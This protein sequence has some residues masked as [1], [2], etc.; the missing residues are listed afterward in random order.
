[1][2]R[3]QRYSENDGLQVWKFLFAGCQGWMLRFKCQSLGCVGLMLGEIYVYK[4]FTQKKSGCLCLNPTWDVAVDPE[5]YF[6]LFEFVLLRPGIRGGGTTWFGF[7]EGDGAPE[8]LAEAHHRPTC[9]RTG[10]AGALCW[11]LGKPYPTLG[12]WAPRTCKWLGSPPFISHKKPIWKGSNPIL[13]GLTITMV[14][15]HLLN[16]MILQA[17]VLWFNKSIGVP[18]L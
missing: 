10:V 3:R 1:M 15:N 8:A 12:G 7:H 5:S 14:I 17:M 9:G 4:N 16:G 13:R 2:I 6:E 11:V 18:F